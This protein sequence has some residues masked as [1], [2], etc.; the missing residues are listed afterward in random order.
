M[1]HEHPSGCTWASTP[2][3]TNLPESF[4][5]L[6]S[7]S[8][9][10]EKRAMLVALSDSIRKDEAS[11]KR[12]PAQ[13]SSY[14]DYIPS[15]ISDETF[16][17]GIQAELDSMKLKAPNSRKVKTFWLNT[18]S[19]SYKYSGATHE[20]HL[21]SNYPSISALMDKLNKSDTVPGDNLD[22]C[23]V[24]CY[25]T[26]KKSLTVHAD[27]E[28][29]ICQMSSICNVSIG[30]TRTIEFEPKVSNYKGALVCTFDL[31]HCS[32]NIMKPGC[33]Q[34]LKHRVIP[35]EHQV[36]HQNIRYCLSFRKYID[37]S[38]ISSVPNPTGSVEDD[39]ISE[40]ITVS[41]NEP[42][43]FKPDNSVRQHYIDTVLFAGDSHFSRLD[44]EK[45]GK[46]KNS[47]INVINI[48]KGGLNIRKTEETISDFCATNTSYN[49]VKVFVS[50]GTNDIRYC[51]RGVRHLTRPLQLLSE[52]IKL[53]FPKAD[54]FY[55]SLLPLPVVN[56][57][58]VE[59]V[60]SFNDLLYEICTKNKIYFFNVFVDFLGYNYHRNAEMFEEDQTNVHLNS[61]GLCCLASMYKYRIHSKKKFNPLMF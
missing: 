12:S 60:N 38:A 14:V 29:E 44:P 4:L 16:I 45:L 21:I 61:Y 9:L 23:L 24:T 41:P 8:S 30:S 46:G 47:Q 17:G 25:S 11:A 55:Q 50:V 19:G 5:P 34:V 39:F 7:S 31:E 42:T 40:H 26:A 1:R 52:R 33:Q 10:V 43:S 37:T 15:F 28:K 51:T 53:C 48:S 22:S 56:P 27:D 49:V 32:V 20:P 3:M 36:G 35:A 13:L 6:L 59:N 54:V 57:F 2:L 18:S 58:V